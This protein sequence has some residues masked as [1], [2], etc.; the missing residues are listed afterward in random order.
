MYG[1]L[2]E[3]KFLFLWNIDERVQLLVMQCYTFHFL[4]NCQTFQSGYI[5]SH[6]CQQY[7]SVLVSPTSSA[8]FG[9]VSVPFFARSK[10]HVVGS[11]CCLNFHSRDD[12]RR[13]TFFPCAH[14]Q[15]HFFWG[16]VSTTVFSPFSSQICFLIVE[17]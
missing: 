9:V 7:I 17:I 12:I 13:G 11:Q 6:F 15:L 14:R 4:R 10:R 2:C 8:A 5:I 1:F 3:L 16:K